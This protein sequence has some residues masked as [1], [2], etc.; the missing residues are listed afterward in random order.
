[1]SIRQTWQRQNPC[2]AAFRNHLRRKIPTFQM[3]NRKQGHHALWVCRIGKLTEILRQ[4]TSDHSNNNCFS[5][6]LMVL[7][8]IK[9]E[10]LD[11]LFRK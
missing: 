4:S 6:S 1:M 9:L 7:W 2:F 11:L 3:G 5:F 8:L 10:C